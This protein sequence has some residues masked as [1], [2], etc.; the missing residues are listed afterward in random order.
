MEPITT[1]SAREATH[2][3]DVRSPEDLTQ[4][5]QTQ[6]L[7]D[8]YDLSLADLTAVLAGWD[9]PAFRAQQIMRWLYKSLVQDFSEMRNLPLGL[10]RKLE[11]HYRIG[12]AQLVAQKIS[13]DG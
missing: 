10:R 4:L 3:E 9:E 2:P 7:R 13:T 8:I 5:E 11:A 6:D 12:S 1:I